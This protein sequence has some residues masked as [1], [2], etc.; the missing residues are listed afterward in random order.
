MKLKILENGKKILEKSGK[1]SS[2]K[3]W[4]PYT[5]P[6]PNLAMVMSL[7]F[8]LGENSTIENSDT[9]WSNVAFANAIVLWKQLYTP[10]D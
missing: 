10:G 3:M 2:P 8:S 7:S 1:F 5:Q 9:H 4:E 6:I